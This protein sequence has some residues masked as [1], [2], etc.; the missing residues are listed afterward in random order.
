M[1]AR[2]RMKAVNSKEDLPEVVREEVRS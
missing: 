1:K 2:R